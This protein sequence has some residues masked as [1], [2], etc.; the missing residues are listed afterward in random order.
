MISF[1]QFALVCFCNLFSVDRR[2]DLMAYATGR[3]TFV[4]N[5]R[6]DNQRDYSERSIIQL[7]DVDENFPYA[8]LRA[9]D[10]ENNNQ[11]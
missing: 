2:T 3:I 4:P 1:I 7:V 10:V 5:S 8:V 11:V 9:R 6:Q